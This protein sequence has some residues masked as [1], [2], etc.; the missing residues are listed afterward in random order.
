[1]DTHFEP[2]GDKVYIKREAAVSEDGGLVIPDA[3]QE[4]I[5]RG[6]VVA[7]GPGRYDEKGN[8]VPMHVKEGDIVVFEAYAGHDVLMEGEEF[9]VMPEDQIFGR[10][11]NKGV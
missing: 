10:I 6:K 8:L 2:L 3:Y 7:V 4:K 1:M 5:Q 9:L 11:I